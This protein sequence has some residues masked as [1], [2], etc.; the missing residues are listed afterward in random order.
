MQ[1]SP[2][3]VYA[4]DGALLV[5]NRGELQKPRDVC[6]SERVKLGLS[7][8]GGRSECMIFSDLHGARTKFQK[9]RA[10]V[11]YVDVLRNAE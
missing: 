6:A 2:G 7:F 9:R 11:G 4:D 8:S 3:R 10:E 5:N 1:A